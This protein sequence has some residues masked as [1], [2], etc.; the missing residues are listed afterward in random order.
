MPID[1][2]LSTSIANGAVSNSAL[3]SNLSFSGTLTIANGQIK[4]P[5]TQNASAD[6]NTLDDYEEGTW[7]AVVAGESGSITAYAIDSATY[8][9][10]GDTVHVYVR[11]TVSNKGTGS[12]FVVSGL[13]FTSARELLGI[14]AETNLLG[15]T[16]L[17]FTAG[18]GATSFTSRLGSN[19]GGQCLANGSY[20]VQTTYRVQ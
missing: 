13:P 9:K 10:T 8:T 4:F 11:F 2:V 16:G 20:T 12:N 19:W 6:A 1:K 17:M 5:A 3:Q 14:W 15:L 18:T 7:S